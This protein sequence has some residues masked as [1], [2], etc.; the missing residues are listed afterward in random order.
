MPEDFSTT[1]IYDKAFDV[2]TEARPFPP[3]DLVS[4]RY[5]R[6]RRVNLHASL[7]RQ[8]L[9]FISNYIPHLPDQK[10]NWIPRTLDQNSAFGK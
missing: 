2:I 5:A 1:A 4:T 7:F 6:I 9:G 3:S 8:N 10:M